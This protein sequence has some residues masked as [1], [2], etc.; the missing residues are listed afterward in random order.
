MESKMIQVKYYFK[1]QPTQLYQY[2]SKHK[3]KLKKH[4][5]KNIRTM[6]TSDSKNYNDFDELYEDLWERMSG[7]A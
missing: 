2:S 7:S 5:K 6:S 3:N 1:E 4:S